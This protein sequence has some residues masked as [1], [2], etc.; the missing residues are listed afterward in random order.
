M[1]S[2]NYKVRR[3]ITVPIALMHVFTHHAGME[4][5]QNEAVRKREEKQREMDKL[6]SKSLRIYQ[7]MT[8]IQAEVTGLQ[9]HINAWLVS[10]AEQGFASIDIIRTKAQ[11]ICSL[12][13]GISPQSLQKTISSEKKAFRQQEASLALPEGGVE[14]INARFREQEEKLE[15]IKREVAVHKTNY[16][17][18]SKTHK[19][20]QENYDKL[21]D[22]LSGT[23]ELAYQEYL[24]NKLYEG[25]LVF[26]HEK[27]TLI[28]SVDV[29][30]RECA[31]SKTSFAGHKQLSGGE[32]SY[33][34][35]C[36][37]LAFSSVSP[38]PWQV[39]DEFDVF[40]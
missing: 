12:R 34:N 2:K 13:R 14:A 19:K 9:N 36:L 37:L 39:L 10:K 23:V 31:K 28:S 6:N 4:Q 30:T 18:L 35:V 1:L 33:S 38:C 3:C 21:R 7:N 11:E 26:D 15:N 8:P 27:L 20:L 22:F 25:K 24:K 32:N 16:L 5:V 40:M 17:E 29:N